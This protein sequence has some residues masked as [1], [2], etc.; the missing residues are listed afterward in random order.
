MFLHLGDVPVI[1]ARVRHEAVLAAIF[2]RS[3]QINSLTPIAQSH[4]TSC[5]QRRVEDGAQSA[6]LGAVAR[7]VFAACRRFSRRWSFTSPE[8]C[9]H[10]D[11]NGITP[12]SSSRSP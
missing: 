9:A 12:P 11:S 4:I 7:V 10:S 8:Q 5:L 1:F 6:S 2:N 3:K